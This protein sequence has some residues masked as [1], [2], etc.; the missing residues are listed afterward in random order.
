MKILD[1][2]WFN[3]NGCVGIVKIHDPYEGVKYYIGIA[4]G[5][6]AIEDA[7]YIADWGSFFPKEAGDKLFKF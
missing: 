5:L 2:R 1:V 6:D 3:A 7:K 4:Q